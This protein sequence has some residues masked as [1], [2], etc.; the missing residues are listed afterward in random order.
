MSGPQKLFADFLDVPMYV[1]YTIYIV[2][3]RNIVEIPIV[4]FD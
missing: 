2:H 1:L 4:P 3:G